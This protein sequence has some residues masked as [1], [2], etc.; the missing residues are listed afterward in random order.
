MASVAKIFGFYH[1]GPMVNDNGDFVDRTISDSI[2]VSHI[3]TDMLGPLW[4]RVIADLPW[5]DQEYWEGKQ[6]EMAAC[7]AIRPDIDYQVSV[8]LSAQ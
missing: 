7:C 4:G 6:R 5:A 8:E 2:A 3:I 1:T